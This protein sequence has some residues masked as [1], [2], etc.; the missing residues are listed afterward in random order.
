MSSKKQWINIDSAS[1]D[2]KAE[3]RIMNTGASS[4][5]ENKD[6]ALDLQLTVTRLE[7][8]K[9]CNPTH[10][11]LKITVKKREGEKEHLDVLIKSGCS[12]HEN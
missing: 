12:S 4:P 7:L 11:H 6:M 8:W 3:H 10:W 9:E 1:S 5:Q 2:G